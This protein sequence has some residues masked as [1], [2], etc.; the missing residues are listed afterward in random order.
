[1]GTYNTSDYTSGKHYQPRIPAAA[2]DE[3]WLSSQC[4]EAIAHL[5]QAYMAPPLQLTRDASAAGRIVVKLRDRMVEQLRQD[6]NG[7]E[8]EKKKKALDRLNIALTLIVGVEY[9]SVGVRRKPIEQA[10]DLLESIL[11]D[12]LF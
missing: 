6:G 9:P 8:T 12:G 1:M 10:R 5:E 3:L 2:Q 11:V 4:R 7:A